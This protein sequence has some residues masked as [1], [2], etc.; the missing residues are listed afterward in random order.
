MIPLYSTYTSVSATDGTTITS[1]VEV[2]GYANIMPSGCNLQG[3]THQ[4]SVYNKLYTTR[5]F[6]DGTSIYTSCY[7]SVENSQSISES[8]TGRTPDA[9]APHV[10]ST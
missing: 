6:I 1:Y 4:G 3:V 8:P 10:G 7:I 5:G 2:E 9:T